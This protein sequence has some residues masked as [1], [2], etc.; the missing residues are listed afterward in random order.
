MRPEPW[1]WTPPTPPVVPPRL[2]PKGASVVV[3]GGAAQRSMVTSIGV[4]F[5]NAVDLAAGAFELKPDAG[6]AVVRF[7]VTTQLVNGKTVATITFPGLL[8]GSLA[9]GAFTFT[10]RADKVKAGGTAMVAD[11][12]TAL[13][14][15]FGDLDGDR[16]YD[17]ASRWMLHERLGQTRGQMGYQA[18]FDF[19]GNGVIDAADEL[20][21][22]RHWGRSV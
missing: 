4:A 5:D 16:T 18:E 21:V 19:D 2:A 6:G 3:N 14:R 11:S 10:V 7:A 22:V 9:D 1:K 13:H 12:T 20:Q 8:G 17:R 15:L